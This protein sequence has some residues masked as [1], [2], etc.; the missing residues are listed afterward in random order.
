[1]AIQAE[2]TKSGTENPLAT[3]RKFSRKVQGVG[4]IKTMR[5]RRYY[6]RNASKTVKKKR[7]LKMIKRRT[8]YRK[9]IKE[10]KIV[11]QTRRGSYT[12]RTETQKPTLGEGTPI[13]R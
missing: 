2:V 11:E 8:E 12:P 7:A 9:A 1:M 4:L 13:A 5:A 3:I 10:G 6:T